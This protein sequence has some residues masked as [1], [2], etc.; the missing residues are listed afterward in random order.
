MNKDKLTV[1]EKLIE[2][3]KIDE[4]QLELSKLAIGT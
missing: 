2:K 3:E 4:A 1:I